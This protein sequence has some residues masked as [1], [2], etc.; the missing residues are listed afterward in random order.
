MP[1]PPLA[2]AV[3]A[4]Q[5]IKEVEKPVTQTETPKEATNAPKSTRSGR[6]SVEEIKRR[7][8][9]PRELADRDGTW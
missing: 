1:A 9:E 7:N 6:T 3:E 4:M 8:S 2:E 5:K